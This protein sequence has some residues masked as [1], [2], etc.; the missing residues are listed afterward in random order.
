MRK[1][2]FV[3][4]TDTFQCWDT[5]LRG[6]RMKKQPGTKTDVCGTENTEVYKK[7][8]MSFITDQRLNSQLTCTKSLLKK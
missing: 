8:K 6:E 3:I 1:Q 5:G 2:T 7:K 4:V